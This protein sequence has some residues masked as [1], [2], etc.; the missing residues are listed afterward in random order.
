MAFHGESSSVVAART[1]VRDCCELSDSSSVS[2]PSET[3]SSALGDGDG[4]TGGGLEAPKIWLPRAKGL[5]GVLSADVDIY[6][7]RNESGMSLCADEKLR[8]RRR[9]WFWALL[10]RPPLLFHALFLW[11]AFFQ[12]LRRI[13]R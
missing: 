12:A 6:T 1:T 13:C 10:V 8:L 5:E 4:A 9:G 7:N 2:L 11:L 3:G